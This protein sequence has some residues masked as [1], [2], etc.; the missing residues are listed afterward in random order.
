MKFSTF[1]IFIFAGFLSAACCFPSNL[2]A[3]DTSPNKNF[4][5]GNPRA[6]KQEIQRNAS[7][8]ARRAFRSISQALDQSTKQSGKA[9]LYYCAGFTVL[10]II[11]AALVYWQILKR[12]Q[13]ER[14]LNDPKCL[15]RELNLAHQLSEPEKRFMQELSAQHA[16]PTPLT[17]FVEPKFLMDAWEND[18]YTSSRPTVRR[19]LSKLFEISVGAG[20]SSS[21]LIKS[22][23]EPD[24]TPQGNQA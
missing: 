14:E 8:D 19:L 22:N 23:A 7:D 13:L 9:F 11:I 12:K 2:S 6:P 17:L 16:L 10:A 15:V 1:C 5:K 21:F 24:M 18:A 3:Q 20:E 4:L